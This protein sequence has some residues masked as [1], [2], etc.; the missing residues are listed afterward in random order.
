M[1]DN[2]QT[3]PHIRGTASRRVGEGR[4]RR[5]GWLRAT[6]RRMSRSL[7][8]RCSSSSSNSIWT[9]RCCAAPLCLRQKC[10]TAR[11]PTRSWCPR[12]RR[13]AG[14]TSTPGWTVPELAGQSLNTGW[15]RQVGAWGRSR[16]F[17]FGWVSLT[18]GFFI[19]Y[20]CFI[21][22]KISWG[23]CN[24]GG[25]IQATRA[26]WSNAKFPIHVTSGSWQVMTES[27]DSWTV[28]S[29]MGCAET[30][31]AFTL[32]N[33]VF[34]M[35]SESSRFDKLFH[36]IDTKL[37]NQQNKTKTREASGHSYLEVMWKKLFNTHTICWVDVKM[38]SCQSEQRRRLSTCWGEFLSSAFILK[39]GFILLS[40]LHL[41]IKW[42]L[43]VWDDISRIRYVPL[44]V[45]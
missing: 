21:Y 31:F 23:G 13:C 28:S 42:M 38:S 41:P 11:P 14:I 6:A 33:N 40:Y 32:H 10:S 19:G 24:F 4:P 27:W 26:G 22:G 17:C 9:W 18:M 16:P 34:N 39:L 15:P 35:W 1:Q 44:G 7:C 2:L 12:P 45:F 36:P 20:T 3:S 5:G 29:A 37:K 30:I 43:N 8:S 25:L